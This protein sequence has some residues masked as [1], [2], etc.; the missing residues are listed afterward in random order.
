[1]TVK[2]KVKREV[3]VM[4]V[5]RVVSGVAGETGDEPGTTGGETGAT[6]DEPG[7]E[8][9]E[10]G[11]TGELP[12]ADVWGTVVG[13][14]GVFG[15]GSTVVEA[16]MVEVLRLVE[17]RVETVCTEAVKIVEVVNLC[18]EVLLADLMGL[19]EVAS[20]VV[21][22][23]MVNDLIE[24]VFADLKDALEALLVLLGDTRVVLEILLVV[25]ADLSELLV[26]LQG[27]L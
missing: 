23:G 12:G 7:A 27:T 26:V 4:R 17:F 9:W 20:V 18:E 6:G 15:T 13:P 10:A 16:T 22:Q 25:L 21:L 2:P 5:V 19:A 24:V 3:V 8:G 11:A 14:T 1:M